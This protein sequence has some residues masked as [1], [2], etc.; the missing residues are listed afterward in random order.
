VTFGSDV[1]ENCKD[2]PCFS[3]ETKPEINLL[4]QFIKKYKMCGIS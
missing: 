1:V 2:K 4:L 3:D